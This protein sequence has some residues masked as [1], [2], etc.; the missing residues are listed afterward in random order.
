M[1]K[2]SECAAQDSEV[3]ITSKDKKMKTKVVTST[4]WGKKNNWG[5]C[6]NFI[7]DSEIKS[8]KRIWR[9]VCVHKRIHWVDIDYIRTHNTWYS[10][11]KI[12]VSNG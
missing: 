5:M 4:N 3:S 8:A 2:V 7:L 6:I 11:V 9:T 1:Y 10:K 12:A